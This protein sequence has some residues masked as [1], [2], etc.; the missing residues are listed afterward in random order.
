MRS[1]LLEIG[2]EELPPGV[3][4]PAAEEVLRRIAGLF[5]EHGLTTG[6][7]EVFYTPRRL[8]VRIR[9]VPEEK[10]GVV[11][12]IQGPPKRVGFDSAGKPTSTA[13]GFARA[14]GKMVED[15]YVKETPKGEYLFLKKEIPPV[16]V[17]ALLQ[18][19]LPGLILS[20]PFPKTMRW[21]ERAVRFSRPVRW[22]LCLFGAEVVR[23]EH[24]GLVAGN[25]T[26]AHRNFTTGPVVVREPEDYEQVLL[27]S[28]VIVSH[29]KRRDEIMKRCATLA[30]EKDGEV[31]PDPEL[32]TETVNTTEFPVPILGKFNPD[33]LS[34]PREVLVTAL[35]MHQRCFSLQDRTG[36]LLPYFI[37]VAN[38][39]G[40]DEEHVRFW[41]ERAIES[42]LR[43]ARFFVEFD[44]KIGLEPLVEEEKRVVWIEGLGSYY[45][46]TQRIRELSRFLSQ[47]IGHVDEAQLDR[48]AFLC[49]AD[50]LTSIVREKEFTSL[51]G[52]MGG[53]YASLLGEQEPVARAIG[54]HYLPR[55]LDDRLP[56]TVLGGI[57]S[58]ADKVDNI[59]ATYLVGKIPTGSEDPFGVRRQASGVLLVIL[60]HRW[61]VRIPELVTKSL[62]LFGRKENR[63]EEMVRELF[64]ERLSAILADEG[65]RYDIANA[66]LAAIWHTPSEAQLRARALAEFRNRP[67]FERLIVGQKRVA[68]LLRA[69]EVAGLPNPILFQEEAERVL[70]ERVRAVEPRLREMLNRA[71]YSAALE[72]LLSLRESIDRLFD[73]VFV[74][75]AEEGLRRNR[76]QLL[77]YVRA[78]FAQLADFSQIVLEG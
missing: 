4:A 63:V 70:W 72:L 75:C 16:P 47:A 52:V 36:R 31:V 54:E 56:V 11:V 19:N 22:I 7:G 39:T 44:L 15:L 42:R 67:E 77:G 27:A 33:Y 29:Q 60:Q 74:M 53:I 10:P 40:C 32:V 69:Q 3:I 59:V 64:R 8:A 6:P 61:P 73:D 12:E 50:L 62:A 57:L 28:M 65:I 38:T 26:R 58:I 13:V 17:M 2:T 18:E 24:N 46:K 23:F 49:K 9:D 51:Q 45:E 48:A 35:K 41:Y 14:Q 55:S 37:A 78:L 25:R 43:D 5:A 66:V 68:N 20:L 71:D 30:E 34:L 76:L 1:F 21:N